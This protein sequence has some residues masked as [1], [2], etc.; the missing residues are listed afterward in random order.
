MR[1]AIVAFLV[2][3]TTIVVGIELAGRV[4]RAEGKT[5]EPKVGRIVPVVVLQPGEVKEITLA[6]R[7]TVG[8][9]RSG[10]LTIREMVATPQ[11]ESA[12]N[13]MWQKDGVTVQI[14][15]ASAASKAAEASIYGPLKNKNLQV[16]TVKVTAGKD[17]KPG[18]YEL[19]V[20]DF[21]CS[22]DCETDL[23]VLVTDSK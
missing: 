12:F 5:A 16:F 9:T 11:K 1:S 6:S 21:T 18:L 8:L 20:A 17:A 13:R 14:P 7:C 22:G 3:V 19:H 23:R 2:G 15:E 4:V 10:G